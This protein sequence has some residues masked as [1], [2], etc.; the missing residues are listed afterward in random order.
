ME[1]EKVTGRKWWICKSHLMVCEADPQ[2][3]PEP[4]PEGLRCP[5]PKWQRGEADCWIV[6]VY[7][8]GE[9]PKKIR[10]GRE[11]R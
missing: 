10:K 9:P 2:G 1:K 8:G 11:R 5:C 3:S 4:P 7:E 6:P